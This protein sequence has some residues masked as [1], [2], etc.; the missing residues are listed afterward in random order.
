MSRLRPS[1][2]KSW[3]FRR[4][5][6]PTLSN[7]MYQK[8]AKKTE[9]WRTAVGLSK[10]MNIIG[11][12]RATKTTNKLKSW[13]VGL[14]RKNLS[15]EWLIR[16][17]LRFLE[18]LSSQEDGSLRR[19]SIVSHST[20]ELVSK[21]LSRKTRLRSW[22]WKSEW[23]LR[24]SSRIWLIEIPWSLVVKSTW[25]Q[26][27]SYL[28]KR[29]SI[30]RLSTSGSVSKLSRL[31]RSKSLLLKN[32]SR[33]RIWLARSQLRLSERKTTLPLNQ[34]DGMRN[35]DF[36]QWLLEKNF[37][38]DLAT[39]LSK[40]SGIKLLLSNRICQLK[41][42][43][44]N[45]L[46]KFPFNYPSQSS[47]SINA[48]D[49]PIWPTRKFL[50]GKYVLKRNWPKENSLSRFHSSSANWRRRSLR[51]SWLIKARLSWQSRSSCSSD[52]FSQ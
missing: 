33:S 19:W 46:T 52:T 48:Q 22:S 8:L 15:K 28:P 13:C 6:R 26:N 34:S 10:S 2:P 3:L 14:T 4:L 43:N 39:M 47:R 44:K 30:L 1:A 42:L 5:R 29:C 45:W 20:S 9:T 36:Q 49:L 12:R 21:Q 27:G 41:S 31:I 24:S 37:R 23:R 11:F 51:L 35:A 38:S 17:R 18:K 40:M 7:K 25:L 32:K 16:S 50:I